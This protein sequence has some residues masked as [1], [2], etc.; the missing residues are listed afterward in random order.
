MFNEISLPSQTLTRVQFV[1]DIIMCTSKP[2]VQSS[3]TTGNQ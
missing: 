1:H 2:C 3:A